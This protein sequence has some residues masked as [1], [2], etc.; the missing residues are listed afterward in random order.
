MPSE[1]IS[2]FVDTNLLIYAIDPSDH[3]KRVLASGQLARM[4]N[5]R[6]LVLSAQSLNEFYRVVTGRRRLMAREDARQFIESLSSFC[7]APSGFQVTQQAWRIQDATNFGWWDCLLL[8]AASLAGVTY[9]L[10]E[11]MQH[12]QRLFG[13]TILNPF[14]LDP[15]HPLF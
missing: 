5:N 12:E 14:R 15:R 8:G 1:K 9:F 10:S 11:D 2:C 6:T 7:V 4:I 13:M 3:E